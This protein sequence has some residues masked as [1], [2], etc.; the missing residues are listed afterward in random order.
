MTVPEPRLMVG[1]RAWKVRNRDDGGGDVMV[2]RLLS[3]FRCYFV[4]TMRL[5][6]WEDLLVVERELAYSF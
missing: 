4:S 3:A 2:T 5:C 1:T 6:S